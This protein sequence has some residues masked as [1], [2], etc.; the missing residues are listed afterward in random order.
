MGSLTVRKKGASGLPLHVLR[1]GNTGIG[2]FSVP[3]GSIREKARGFLREYS[4]ETAVCALLVVGV[5]IVYAQAAFF[6]FVMIDDVSYIRENYIVKQGLTL[7][8]IAWA[9]TSMYAANWHPLTWLS[10][11]ADMTVFDMRPGMYH[12][13]N[14]LLHAV[15]AVLLFVFLRYATGDIWKNAAVAALFALHP[16]HV[17]SVAWIS[18]RKDVLSSLFW[19]LTMISYV[20]YARQPSTKRYLLMAASFALGLMAKPMIVTLPFVLLL[21][22][23]WPLERLK[24]GGDKAAPGGGA[25]TKPAAGL[26]GIL[27]LVSEKAPLFLLSAAS[28]ALTFAAQKQGGAISTLGNVTMGTRVANSLTSYV[29]YL[30]NM[31]WPVNLGVFYPLNRSVS[32]LLAVGALLLILLVTLAVLLAARRLPYLAFGWLWYLGTLVP[33]IGLVQ[34]G[35]QSMADRYTYMPLVGVF[36]MGAWGLTDLFGRWR[37]GKTVLVYWFSIVLVLLTG[38]AWAQAGTWKDSITL[39]THNIEITRNNYLA[40]NN[41]GCALHEKGN[42]RGAIECY[43]KALR[44]CPS[45]GVAH[46]NLAL[47]LGKEGKAREALEHYYIA[48]S[49]NPNSCLSHLHIGKGLFSFGKVSESVQEYRK[50]LAINPHHAGAWN[51]LG[52]SLTVEGKTDEARSCYLKALEISPRFTEARLNLIREL[53]SQGKFEDALRQMEIGL[54]NDPG[55]PALRRRFAEI[56]RKEGI[57]GTVNR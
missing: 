52:F 26:S 36:V 33:V 7:K 15:N 11:M 41:L 49:L 21:L 29:A 57:P 17:E 48:L 28:C 39:F 43:R 37:H 35:S 24:L 38:L 13:V 47:A 40:Y 42:I 56:S 34:V 50:A 54:K 44:I 30:W 2:K 4:R 25:P 5:A 6:D 23:Y 53:E 51:S 12:L 3:P 1:T 14:V 18:E 20:R 9:F 46:T 27:P 19:I 32:P 22:D 55:N 16:L 8:G 45:Y 31:V 10:H